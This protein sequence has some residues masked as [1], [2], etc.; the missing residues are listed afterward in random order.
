MGDRTTFEIR[1]AGAYD[2]YL[3][4]APVDVDPQAVAAAA[5]ASAR[6]PSI[7]RHGW[8]LPAWRGPAGSFRLVALVGLLVALAVGTVWVAGQLPV[9]PS[10][11]PMSTRTPSAPPSR[12]TGVADW[13]EIPFEYTLPVGSSVHWVVGNTRV[14]LTGF[15][16]GTAAPRLDEDYGLQ[17][18]GAGARGM[19]VVS[20]DD[21]VIHPC[22]MSAS[23][24][25][26]VDVRDA[27]A[28]FLADLETIGKMT[29][30]AAESTTVDGRPALA[31]SF[32][33]AR[34]SCGEGGDVHPFAGSYVRLVLP[35]RLF[36][37][38]VEG[39]TIMI[40]LWA[41]GTDDDLAAWLPTAME[42]V[43]SIRFLED[44]R[45]S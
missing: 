45:P 34:W 13:F 8:T 1:L 25:S 20:V 40:Q 37:L 22:P 30:T 15:L 29:F 6:R 18:R 44:S 26:R 4:G 41:V 35:S 21:A 24:P 17:Q 32:D 23:S 43:E 33:A 12:P 31:T 3:A 2:R 36:L 14:D 5:V 42:F 11:S 27:P 28:D 19:A 16:D 9:S 38:E 10:P 7:T 39:K